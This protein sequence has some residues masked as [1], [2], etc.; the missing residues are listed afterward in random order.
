MAKSN[1]WAQ[2]L[3]GIR[4]MVSEL[5]SAA[6]DRLNDLDALSAGIARLVKREEDPVVNRLGS[7]G[8]YLAQDGAAEVSSKFGE[9][10]EHI[11]AAIGEAE[12]RAI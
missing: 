3:R 8:E 9:L 11:D 5:A 4:V 2:R 10:L 6:D 12:G 7:I 1:Q